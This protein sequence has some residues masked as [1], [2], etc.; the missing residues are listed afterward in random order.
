M[1]KKFWFLAIVVFA[2]SACGGKKESVPT[3]VDFSP[4]WVKQHPVDPQYYVGVGMVPKKFHPN[5]YAQQAKKNAL[6]DLASEIQVN[7]ASNSM[8]F[9]VERGSDFREEY[10]DFIQVKTNQSIKNFEQVDVYESES[11][12]WVYYRLSKAQYKQDRAKEIEKAINQSMLLIEQGDDLEANK[13][14]KNALVSYLKALDPIQPYL[15][16]QLNATYK[17]EPVFLGNLLFHKIDGLT[18]SLHLIPENQN[19]EVVIGQVIPSET[20]K[21]TLTDAEGSK[22]GSFPIIFDYSNGRPDQRRGVTGNDGTVYG[23]LNKIFN[24]DANQYFEAKIDFAKLVE[25]GKEEEF[26]EN[27]LSS[28]NANVASVA[29]QVRYPKCT[30]NINHTSKSTA[31]GLEETKETIAQYLSKKGFIITSSNP[32]IAIDIEV[33]TRSLGKQGDMYF[34]QLTGILKV[35]EANSKNTTYTD[36]LKEFKGVQ[37]TEEKAELNAFQKLSEYL[38]DTGTP[39][40]YRAYMK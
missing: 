4:A 35:Q 1:L 23:S 2:L 15:G 5:D 3:P 33:N 21:F 26:T 6:N 31:I 34:V 10:K 32:D 11:E 9:S 28:L 7:V 19:L 30:I 12:F 39:R 25:H 14:H 38:R 27:L 20:L 40:L 17:G 22:V 29:L 13:D 18:K 24:A 8:L 37:L 36:K 16:E